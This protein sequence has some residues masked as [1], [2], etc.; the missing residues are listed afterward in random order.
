VGAVK[1]LPEKVYLRLDQIRTDGG[2][3]SRA[4]LNEET[5][6]EYAELYASGAPMPAVDVFHDGTDHWL[7]DGFHRYAG[8]GLAGCEQIV[9][10]IHQG[11]RR[12]AVLFSCG[13]NGKHGLRRT[14]ADKRRAVEVLL[15]DEEWSSKSDRWIADACCVGHQL[16]STLRATLGDSSNPTHRVTADGR[17]YPAERAPRGKPE[18][19]DFDD[20]PAEEPNPESRPVEVDDFGRCAQCGTS[21]TFGCSCDTG[22]PA[23]EAPDT[24][25]VTPGDPIS[26]LEALA[27]Q[28]QS[29][30]EYASLRRAQ[31][32]VSV[33]ISSRAQRMI[34]FALDGGELAL[35]RLGLDWSVTPETLRAAYRAASLKMHPDRGGSQS[36]FVALTQARDLVSRLLEA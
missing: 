30:P 7:S 18:P 5:V 31:L 36:E 1:S 17:E 23:D 27:A 29:D 9:S 14:N 8:A 6:S 33:S 21:P 34:D 2:T 12:D 11:S 15:R 25:D 19:D 20:F 24:G 35:L 3:Q 16:V 26:I 10:E 32:A 4:Q 22:E 28:R 13:A